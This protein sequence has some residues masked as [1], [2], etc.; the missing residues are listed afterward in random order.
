MANRRKPSPT[1]RTRSHPPPR[2]GY[3][4]ETGHDT[5]W[6]GPPSGTYSRAG[7]PAH[8]DRPEIRPRKPVKKVKK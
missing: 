8:L 1:G 2:H 7:M 4:G 3:G 6:S 5:S